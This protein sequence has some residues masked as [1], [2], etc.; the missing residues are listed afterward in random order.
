MG[1]AP[2]VRF[3]T[4]PT[5]ALAPSRPNTGPIWSFRRKPE[6]RRGWEGGD[7]L[8]PWER[9]EVRVSPTAPEL[10]PTQGSPDTPTKFILLCGLRNT[11][12]IPTKA[13]P[14]CPYPDA[15]RNPE[16]W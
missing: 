2:A 13:C 15:G 12:V 14:L 7:F 16:G 8:S 6:S 11:M 5:L 9:I 4:V 3:I 1:K 10:L